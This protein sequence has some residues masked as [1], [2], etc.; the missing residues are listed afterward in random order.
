MSAQSSEVAL[1]IYELPGTSALNKMT[2]MA[3]LGGAYHVGV[4]AYGLEWSYG[5]SPE[6]SG[7]YMVH[8]GKSSLGTFIERVPL[9][10]APFSA[11][12]AMYILNCMRG[13]WKGSDYDVLRRNCAHF[14]VD[15]VKRLEVKD[16][17]SWVYR[18]ADVGEAMMSVLGLKGARQAAER[19]IPPKGRLSQPQMARFDEEDDGYA[20][21]TGEGGTDDHEQLWRRAERFVLKRAAGLAQVNSRKSSMQTSGLSSAVAKERCC[22]G[23]APAGRPPR[24]IRHAFLSSCGRQEMATGPFGGV[25]GRVLH[26]GA[27]G[28]SPPWFSEDDRCDTQDGPRGSDHSQ[29]V[30]G[31]LQSMIHAVGRLFA[32][33]SGQS[34]DE[35][36]SSHDTS[37]KARLTPETGFDG[38][39]HGNKQCQ[40]PSALRVVDIPRPRARPQGQQVAQGRADDFSAGEILRRHFPVDGNFLS[41]TSSSEDEA[42]TDTSAKI[43]PL[44]PASAH[45][46]TARQRCMARRSRR[47][48]A[49]VCSRTSS[50]IST[51]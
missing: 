37:S 36:Q 48:G 24:L 5:W 13:E 21:G 28:E 16:A 3:G 45:S 4:E 10:Q 40:S 26:H 32:P 1:S 31:Y 42:G 15:L 43:G 33:S 44:A 7:V 20:H 27:D 12:A 34:S 29:P 18:L 25:A 41:A 47:S 51:E 19:A 46:S 39:I 50:S 22:P 35:H 9:G 8:I 6:G 14:A 23:K 11:R 38:V 2:R 49:E 30:H 17:P